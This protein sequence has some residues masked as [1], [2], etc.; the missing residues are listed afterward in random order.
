[1]KVQVF[2]LEKKPVAE[3]ELSEEVFGAEVRPH[4][5]WEVVNWQRAKRRAGTHCTKV[6]SE[7]SGGGKKPWKQKGTGRARQGSIRAAQWV[8]GATVQGPRPRDYEYRMP[9]KKRRAALVSALSM[10]VQGSKLFVVSELSF[11]RIKTKDALAVLK[12][13]EAGKALFVD[14]TTRVADT[15][16]PGK[17]Q[18][19]E[20][21]RMSVRNLP[22]VKY[23][24]AE[25]LNVEDLL[26]HDVV[27]ISHKAVTQVQEALTR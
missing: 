16:G 20:N 11:P 6:R 25:G 7:V 19:N 8:G 17:P 2:D 9:K 15:E 13:F 26:G 27:F 1:M 21:L 12:A 22:G 5:F 14:V 4:L 18:H 24:A 23:L 3:I 10:K